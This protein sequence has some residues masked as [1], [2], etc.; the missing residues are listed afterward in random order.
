MTRLADI[1][2]RHPLMVLALAILSAFASIVT[3]TLQGPEL[4]LSRP[5]LIFSERRLRV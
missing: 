4:G 5:L 3:L 1:L 2:L